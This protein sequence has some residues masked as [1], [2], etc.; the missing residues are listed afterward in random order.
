MISQHKSLLKDAKLIFVLRFRSFFISEIINICLSHGTLFPSSTSSPFVNCWMSKW[1]LRDPYEAKESV[2]G[3]SSRTNQVEAEAVVLNANQKRP[4]SSSPLRPQKK[5]KIDKRDTEPQSY[6]TKT[7]ITLESSIIANLPLLI[8]I[9]SHF[10]WVDLISITDPGKHFIQYNGSTKKELYGLLKEGYKKMQ[11]SF[12]IAT[13]QETFNLCSLLEILSCGNV[14]KSISNK[15]DTL[16]YKTFL[17]RCEAE[18]KNVHHLLS[19]T[20]IKAKKIK[21]EDNSI[22]KFDLHFI[23]YFLQLL[24]SHHQPIINEILSQD[25]KENDKKKVFVYD[26]PV[27]KLFKSKFSEGKT[28]E[29]AIEA[30]EEINEEYHSKYLYVQTVLNQT[31]NI[32]SES[33]G[34]MESKEINNIVTKKTLANYRTLGDETKETLSNVFT[35]GYDHQ[36]SGEDLG[37]HL[38]KAIDCNVDKT[39]DYKELHFDID[40]SFYAS[41]E[42]AEENSEKQTDKSDVSPDRASESDNGSVTL[43][44]QGSKLADDFEHAELNCNEVRLV[45]NLDSESNSFYFDAVRLKSDFRNFQDFFLFVS[46]HRL[47]LFS[48]KVIHV[49]LF[50]ICSPVVGWSIDGKSQHKKET[51]SDEWDLEETEI[52]NNVMI[53]CQIRKKLLLVLKIGNCLLVNRTHGSISDL[54][55]VD[56]NHALIHNSCCFMHIYIRHLERHIKQ[57]SIESITEPPAWR[58]YLGKKKQE[59]FSSLELAKSMFEQLCPVKLL[60]LFCEYESIYG[61]VFEENKIS[62]PFCVHKHAKFG[63]EYLHDRFK[64]FIDW[65]RRVFSEQCHDNLFAFT[66]E[67]ITTIVNIAVKNIDLLVNVFEKM[68]NLLFGPTDLERN[69]DVG[70]GGS[71]SNPY[72]IEDCK[73]A[74]DVFADKTSKHVGDVLVSSLILEFKDELLQNNPIKNTLFEKVDE[75]HLDVFSQVSSESNVP[76]E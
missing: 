54:M 11:L 74:N 71:I 23:N 34:S 31:R 16:V 36:N 8:S 53:L 35:A 51:N 14:F 13:I 38:S 6:R 68:K 25:T 69:E 41:I 75:T 1:F 50:D 57:W 5:R 19:K 20:L 18:F 26:V 33:V 21:A 30:L 15:E 28:K 37:K 66:D 9:V 46:T 72:I 56:V 70:H 7:R 67:N 58:L 10:V 42:N 2:A 61:K 44:E 62:F 40:E 52:E 49:P 24:N 76:S 12:K 63:C 27:V 55:S 3:E 64:Q 43:N 29:E 60:C 59:Y 17:D 65:F 32:F 73:S 47:E 4:A 22:E 48:Q 39:N 45:S